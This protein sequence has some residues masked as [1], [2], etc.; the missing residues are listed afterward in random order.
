[1]ATLI[2]LSSLS[3]LV[4]AAERRRAQQMD[5]GAR[6]RTRP[7]TLPHAQSA[8]KRTRAQMRPPPHGR[9]QAV[10]TSRSARARAPSH[11]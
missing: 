1:M 6:A 9:A 4:E 5:T 3:D 8:K 7:R 10:A 11:A 2:E